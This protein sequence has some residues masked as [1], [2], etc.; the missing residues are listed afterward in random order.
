MNTLYDK[1]AEILEV[2]TV[3]PGDVLREFTCWD[4]LTVLS[5]IAMMD[6]SYG[7]NADAKDLKE[8]ITVG[9]LE[10]FIEARKQ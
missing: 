1:L 8:V 7:V 3:K 9:D 4:S 5:I 2:E 6:K 10:H